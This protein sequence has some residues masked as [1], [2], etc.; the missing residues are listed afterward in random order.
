MWKLDGLSDYDIRQPF[1]PTGTNP[2]GLI[3]HSTATHL[4]YFGEVY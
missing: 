1:T 4:G 2:L 3:K